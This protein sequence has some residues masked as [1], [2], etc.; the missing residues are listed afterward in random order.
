MKTHQTLANSRVR[1]VNLLSDWQRLQPVWDDFVL[2]HPKGGIFHTS[3]MVRV[4]DAATGYSPIPLAAMSGDG[5]ILALMVTVRVQTLPR[6]LDGVSSRSIAFAEPLCLGDPHSIE[7]LCK[8]IEA[9]DQQT[10]WNTLFAEIRPLYAAGPEKHALEQ[11]GYAHLD[12]LNYVV[13]LTKLQDELWS[14]VRPSARASIRKCERQGFHVRQVSGDLAVDQLYHFLK[15]TYHRARVPLP[16][17]SLFEAA[18]EVLGPSGKI[19][20]VAAYRGDEAVGTDAVL[21][22]KDR[23]FGWYGGALR[24]KGVSPFEFMQWNEIVWG[25][26]HSYQIY[27]FGGA[28]WPDEPYGVRDFKA[29]F[30]GE[31]VCYGRY[32]KVYSPRLLSLAERVYEVARSLISPK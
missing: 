5:K 4:F 8:L 31:L 32:R 23:V 10:R 21:A 12:Y 3:D 11:C 19:K 25:C 18:Q 6:P 17:R 1:V 7:A 15:L 14:R 29:R 30:G 16:D 13:D 27:D 28:G 9:H 26:E 2:Q 24:M 22:F 20:F